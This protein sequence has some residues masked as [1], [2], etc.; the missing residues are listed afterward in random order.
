MRSRASI[1]IAV[2]GLTI[3]LVLPASAAAKPHVLPFRSVQLHLRGSGGYGI[4]LFAIGLP[5]P[6]KSFVSIS[7]SRMKKGSFFDFDSSTYSVAGAVSTKRVRADLGPYGRIS[8]RFQPSGP[9][10]EDKLFPGCHGR[11]DTSQRGV[12]VGTIRF[13]GDGGFT[14]VDAE[15]AKGKIG[16]AGSY[17]CKG[18]GH[19]PR[20]PHHA[21]KVEEVSLKATTPHHTLDFSAAIQPQR[22]S[23][24]GIPAVEY[25]ASSNQFCG[26]VAVSRS[27]SVGGE[28]SS[29]VF[30]KPLSSATVTPPAPFSGSGTFSRDPAGGA[31]TWTGNLAVAFPG[32]DAT[33]VG[34]DFDAKLE[35]RRVD[36]SAGVLYA[37]ESSCR[38]R[39]LSAGST[40]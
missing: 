9:A 36:P 15:R 22:D 11:P 13:R 16:T 12:F 20:P 29:F 5:K 7:A 23:F 31:A 38:G 26:R 4:S 3:A 33:I 21:K 2:A 30:D 18:G 24:P 35:R 10:K 19:L 25:S 6:H 17:S 34:D 39:P 40:F 32:L 14:E 28:A 8:L 1:A 37:I 27:V